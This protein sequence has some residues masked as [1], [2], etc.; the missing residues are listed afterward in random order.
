M[1]LRFYLKF[2]FALSVPISGSGI[3]F[4]FL[5]I[6]ELKENNYTI[7]GFTQQQGPGTLRANLAV[8]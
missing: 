2:G 5:G 1:V 8:L 6:P 4:F 7:A 3:F